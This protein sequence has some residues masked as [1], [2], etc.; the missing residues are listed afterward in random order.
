MQ[1]L[2]D[3]DIDA[4][5]AN[6]SRLAA[7]AVARSVNRMDATRLAAFDAALQAEIARLLSNHHAGES[8]LVL[9]PDAFGDPFDLAALPLARPGTGYAVQYLDTDALLDH[10]RRCFAP[11]RDATLRALF[12]RFDDAYD[13]AR[14]WVRAHP[15]TPFPPPLAIV[16]AFFDDLMQR[17]V[18]IYGV[19]KQAP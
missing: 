5:I 7:E 4:A 2:G 3:D 12:P 11:V 1:F 13:A 6:A 10:E 19:L 14:L 17:H 16:P 8:P 18:L 9:G 15:E